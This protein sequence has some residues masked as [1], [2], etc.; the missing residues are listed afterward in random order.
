MTE[1]E[2]SDL[3]NSVSSNMIAGQALFITVLSGYL[4]VA[5][6]IGRNLTTYQ[7]S[8][9]NL[10]FILFGI[11]SLVS[12]AS[13]FGMVFRYSDML[14]EGGLLRARSPMREVLHEQC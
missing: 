8:F 9:I 2:I 7:I 14:V 1:Y 4:A 11:I 3:I 5:Y 10:V 12:Q 13:Q 6:S